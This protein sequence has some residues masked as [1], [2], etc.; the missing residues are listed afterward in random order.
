MQRKA[1]KVEKRS[2]FEVIAHSKFV[3]H[4]LSVRRSEIVFASKILPA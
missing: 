3:P 4:L 2:T 1:F